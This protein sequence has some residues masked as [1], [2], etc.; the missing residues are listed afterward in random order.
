MEALY[1]QMGDVRGQSWAPHCRVVRPRVHPHHHL[2]WSPLAPLW[3]FFGLRLM[4]GKIETPGFVSSNSENISCVTYL[5]HKNNS[6][7]GTGTVASRQ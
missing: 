5:K 7:Q 3:L 6:K 1:R 2:V 4:W